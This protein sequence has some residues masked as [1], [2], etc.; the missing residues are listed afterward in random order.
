MKR[1][2]LKAIV[3]AIIAY[4]FPWMC[5][6]LAGKEMSR[7]FLGFMS[8]VPTFAWGVAELVIERKKCTCFHICYILAAVGMLICGL[9]PRIGIP[10]NMLENVGSVYLVALSVCLL[11]YCGL[12][13]EEKLSITRNGS[14]SIKI[15]LLALIICTVTFAT[16][17]GKF[18]LGY[19]VGILSYPITLAMG[20][21]SSV[22]EEYTWRG[23]LQPLFQQKLGK[24]MGIL[25]TC[26]VWELW[27]T[28]LYIN[29]FQFEQFGEKMVEA[30]ALRI[31]LVISAGIL[32]GWAYMKTNNVWV[33]AAIHSIYNHSHQNAKL[34]HVLNLG[35]ITFFV[36]C[37]ALLLTKEFR[38]DEGV[39]DKNYEKVNEA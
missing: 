4:G 23:M 32:I 7:I 38:R 33:C 27:H 31:M 25:V 36:I 2:Y 12:Y 39:E 1:N 19:Y 8:T 5:A 30:I 18:E 10:N 6:L 16:M 37:F 15:I 24:R 3:F 20:S 14:M 11:L 29:T 26:V 34:A 21:I 13:G 22:G 17:R 35:W 9:A 28:C